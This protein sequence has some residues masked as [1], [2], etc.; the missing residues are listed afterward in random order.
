[1]SHNTSAEFISGEAMD[2]N[3]TVPGAILM[4]GLLHSFCLGFVL[5]QGLKYWDDYPEDPFRKHALVLSVVVLSFHDSLQTLVQDYKLWTIA[6]SQNPWAS[7]IP[8][9]V[10]IPFVVDGQFLKRCN[11]RD[12]RGFFHTSM[13]EGMTGKK[14]WAL[15]PLAILWMSL[16]CASFYITIT[17]GLEFKDFTAS[18]HKLPAHAQRLFRDTMVVFSYWVI[19][20]TVLNVL[21]ALILVTCLFKSKTGV[22]NSDSVINRVILLT[23]QTAILPSI[24][25]TTAL[26]LLHVL[27]RPGQNDDLALFFILITAKFHAIGLLRTLNARARLRQRI[28]STDLGRTTLSQWTWDQDEPTREQTT[29]QPDFVRRLPTSLNPTA[30]LVDPGESSPYTADIQY[31]SIPPDQ[32]SCPESPS[33]HVHFSSPLLDQFERGSFPRRRVSS[34]HRPMQHAT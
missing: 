3:Y 20:G 16:V 14:W 12:L 7:L 8:F 1:M 11:L 26:V 19:A 10:P 28:G 2:Y 29:S 6:V 9:G 33:Q 23:L 27:P 24:S 25:M 31:A 21:V 13:L 17:V 15:Y 4:D 30:T 18:Q 22:D 32:M 34:A 5:A